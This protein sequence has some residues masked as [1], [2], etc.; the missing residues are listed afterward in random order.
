MASWGGYGT[1]IV[2]RASSDT[3]YC[4][5]M[6]IIFRYAF[7]ILMKKIKKIFDYHTSKIFCLRS[8][9]KNTSNS[10]TLYCWLLLF[11]KKQPFKKPYDGG[12]KALCSQPLPF[13][14]ILY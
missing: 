14:L 10:I 11:A 9:K 12:Q 4:L 5:V 7:L 3:S 2:N 8:T 13:L 1:H 6:I